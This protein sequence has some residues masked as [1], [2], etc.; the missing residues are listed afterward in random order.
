MREG[1]ALQRKSLEDFLRRRSVSASI[2]F[3]FK[4]QA[5]GQIRRLKLAPVSVEIAGLCRQLRELL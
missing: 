2:I 1:F 3:M 4:P 5:P